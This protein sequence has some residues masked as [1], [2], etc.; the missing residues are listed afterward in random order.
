[1]SPSEVLDPSFQASSWR[2]RLIARRRSKEPQGLANDISR[3][4]KTTTESDVSEAG[5]QPPSQRRRFSRK[6]LGRKQARETTETSPTDPFYDP[7]TQQLQPFGTDIPPIITSQGDDDDPRMTFLDDPSDD[8]SNVSPTSPVIQRASSVRVSRPKIVQHSNSSAGSVP[9][10]CPQ[11]NTP[12]STSEASALSRRPRTPD[13]GNAQTQVHPIEEQ[14]INQAGLTEALKALNGNAQAKEDA[15]HNA[16][17][18][19][20]KEPDAKSHDTFK[21]SIVSWPDTPSRLEALDTMPTPMGGFGSVRI[22][23]SSGGTFSTSSTNTY[24]SPI[25]ITNGLRLNPPTDGDRKLSRAISAPVRNSRRVMIRPADLVINKAGHDHK[26][27]RENIVSTPYP[28]RQSSIGDIDTVLAAGPISAPAATDELKKTPRLRRARP[29]STKTE[30]TEPGHESTDIAD[31]SSASIT[32]SEKAPE[33]PLATKPVLPLSASLP[34]TSKSDR[35]PSPSAPE[36]L[37][38]DLRLAHRPSAHLTV[39]IEVTDKTTFDDEQ[40]FTVIRQKYVEDLMGRARWWFCARTL[41]SASLNPDLLSTN[42]SASHRR[43][44][45]WYGQQHHIAMANEFDG[46]DLVRYLLNPKLGHRRKLWLLWVRN[47]QEGTDATSNGGRLSSRGTR[48]SYHPQPALG[49]LSRSSSEQ[50][51]KASTSPVFSFMHSR[52]NSGGQPVDG[53]EFSA[54]LAVQSPNN[55]SG[56][57][58]LSKQPSTHLPRMPFNSSTTSSPMPMPQTPSLPVSFARSKSLAMSSA[59]PLSPAHHLPI[60]RHPRIYLC[61]TFSLRLIAFV[62][63]LVFLLAALTTVLWILFGYPGRSAAQG[64]GTTVV[65]GIV[66]EVPWQRD[67]QSRVGV[68]F[69]MGVAVLLVGVL[70]EIGWVW[71][72]WVLV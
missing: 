31:K 64:D 43:G 63:A 30:R 46:T 36:I 21:E 51:E 8:E 67:A 57:G 10:L 9:K 49:H 18:H 39:E 60:M 4:S 16:V 20:L 28:A 72:S 26:L 61:H 62:T 70:A 40:L 41:E 38:L 65:A 7:V 11:Q 5:L 17:S 42:S 54:S 59:F 44:S 35:F 19:D 50:E 69:V 14:R 47:Q 12:A 1:M 45:S 37:F 32:F 56:E 58:G 15:A 3:W 23:R 52:Q 24:V 25:P 29:L 6:K 22:P 66:F 13:G 71:G 33:I 34:A 53:A 68:G 2:G 48:Q 27:F 55:T